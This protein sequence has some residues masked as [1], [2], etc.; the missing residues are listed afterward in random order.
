[1]LRRGRAWLEFANDEHNQLAAL[2][3]VLLVQWFLA[4][5]GIQAFATCRSQFDVGRRAEDHPSIAPLLALV[6]R[7]FLQPHSFVSAKSDRSTD[8]EHPG[9]STHEA[10]ARHVHE[11]LVARGEVERLA[12]LLAERTSGGSG[13]RNG[14]AGRNLRAR[15][16]A[17][18][19]D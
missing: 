5:R 19:D 3:E 6:D 4:A 10:V 15:V 11:R 17:F 8:G 14:S 2:R 1:T 12:G 9:P 16:R 7:Q 13:A 18:Y